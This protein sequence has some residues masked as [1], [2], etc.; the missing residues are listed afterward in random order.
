M[1]QTLKTALTKAK[2]LMLITGSMNSTLIPQ[3]MR[4]KTDMT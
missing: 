2:C 4:A 3:Y 1:K